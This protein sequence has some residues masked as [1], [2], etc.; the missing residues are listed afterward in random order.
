MA[1]PMVPEKTGQVLIG[2]ELGVEYGV[3]DTNGKQP[4]SHRSFLGDTTTYS[5]AIVQ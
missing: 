5:E 1:L 4:P 2:A 3:E